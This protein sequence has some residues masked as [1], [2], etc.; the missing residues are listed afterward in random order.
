VAQ[1]LEDYQA[2]APA[3]ELMK[4]YG[5]GKGAV[6]GI[7]NEA[8]VTRKQRRMSNEQLTEAAELYHQGWS[9]VRL[10]NHFGFHQSAIW[11]GLKGLGCRCADPGSNRHGL[12]CSICRA[13]A[14]LPSRWRGDDA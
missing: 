5:I 12:R 2:G 13:W 10:G 8:G 1:L 6:L 3:T 9:L 7:L 14:K 4:Q 11:L